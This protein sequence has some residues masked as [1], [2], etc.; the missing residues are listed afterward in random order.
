MHAFARFVSLA[1]ALAPAIV[2]AQ[3]PGETPALPPAPPAQQPP[4]APT[5][6]RTPGADGTGRTY[7][8]VRAGVVVPQH[9]DLEGFTN[10]FSIEGAF[11]YRFNPNLALE[12]SVG[13][14]SMG[15]E[16]SAVSPTVG[17][18]TGKLDFV[19]YPVL[20][21][22]KVILP[23]DRVGL[24]LLAGGGVH[25][26][27]ADAS[28]SVPAMGLSVSQSDSA[29]AFGLHVGGGLDFQVS[30]TVSLGAELKYVIGEVSVLDTSGH[31]DH[32]VIAG[33]LRFT[34]Q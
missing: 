28:A 26:L 7:L 16:M 8:A 29:T 31:F 33:A 6:A 17:T 23:L 5:P 20:V 12:F 34:L 3:S 18:I 11:G 9:D 30:P 21:T 2:S 1:L 24:Y 19:A 22:G 4:L 14:W 15:G 25:F 13:R 32:L 27:T 10:G